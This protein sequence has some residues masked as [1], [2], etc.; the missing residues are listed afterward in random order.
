MDPI[1]PPGRTRQREH[2]PEIGDDTRTASPA[3]HVRA[4]TT[5]PGAVGTP[6]L[7]PRQQASERHATGPSA[8]PPRTTV[9]LNAMR[10]PAPDASPRSPPEHALSEPESPT[11]ELNAWD[12]EHPERLQEDLAAL[13]IHGPLDRSQVFALVDLAVH[14]PDLE[15]RIRQATA[16]L[17]AH[18][19]AGRALADRL[20]PMWQQHC[21]S[22]PAAARVIE[23]ALGPVG[24]LAPAEPSPGSDPAN[25]EADLDALQAEL[26]E[27]LDEGDV[28][29]D[30]DRLEEPLGH[31]IQTWLGSA[32]GAVAAHF[33]AFD[34]EPQAKAF[35][36][37]LERLH[38][39]ALP[40]FSPAAQHQLKEQV[41]TAA[42]MMARDA[43]LC[44]SVFLVAQT[45]LGDCRDNLLDGLSKVMLTVRSHQMALGV[46]MGRIDEAKANHLT[47]QRFR[48]SLLE[49]A[50][51]R[52]ISQQKERTDLP[53]WKKKWLETDS[54]ETMVHAKAALKNSL[55]L[56]PDTAQD[57]TN[58]DYSVL[59]PGDIAALRAEVL[60]QAADP[61]AYR[62]F[63][64]NDEPWRDSM[65]AL[66]KAS[67][68]AINAVR[69]AD[70][71]YEQLPPSD[72][73]S[74]AAFAHAEAG[75][76][77]YAA[78]QSAVDQ[79]LEALAARANG[80]L[81]PHRPPSSQTGPSHA[82]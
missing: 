23:T 21:D 68:E 80:A 16:A 25:L 51:T 75:N 29:G 60:A 78:W 53:P 48:L 52:F 36:R 24:A 38:Q 9:P 18:Q 50:T 63:L 40:T 7:S 37:L 8:L 6:P 27:D 57:L 32:G 74:P 45:A 28:E 33:Q 79:Q 65:Q 62:Q 55:S 31:Q 42:V 20:E 59:G 35:A 15:D 67:F 56:P 10:P 4:R 76:Q 73:T 69:D 34:D 66:H 41:R 44:L 30:L 14:R 81:P 43:D 2:S 49:T 5:G 17:V 47:G 19:G 3:R 77:I 54:V 39:E 82:S 26:D 46:K 72:S 12:I 1:R 71:Y 13:G 70:P 22:H 64:L 11:F 61:Q 58:L